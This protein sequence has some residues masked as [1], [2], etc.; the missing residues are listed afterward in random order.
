MMQE[1]RCSHASSA[2]MSFLHGYVMNHTR[3]CLSRNAQ[4]GKIFFPANADCVATSC[5]L[6]SCIHMSVLYV[7]Q[8]MSCCAVELAHGQGTAD[9]GVGV[10]NPGKHCTLPFSNLQQCYEK[11]SQMDRR[12]SSTHLHHEVLLEASGRSGASLE[13]CATSK[14]KTLVNRVI[15]GP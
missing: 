1:R 15:S 14:Q 6:H 4:K 5:T 11:A 10:I 9:N 12:C 2:Q 7:V 8:C 3:R 13:I